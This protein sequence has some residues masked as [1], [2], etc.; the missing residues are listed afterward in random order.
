[1]SALKELEPSTSRENSGQ[2]Q[3]VFQCA[4]CHQKFSTRFDLFYHAEDC[5]MSAFE[6]EVHKHNSV[7]QPST[8]QNPNQNPGPGIIQRIKFTLP[9]GTIL[10]R[11]FEGT[12]GLV[13]KVGIIGK[14]K[15]DLPE[16]K[17]QN[18]EENDEFDEGPP[19]LECEAE[20]TFFRPEASQAFQEERKSQISNLLKEPTRK[21]MTCPICHL[22]LYRHNF[23]AHYR[24]HTNELPYACMYCDKR[25]RTSSTLKV[26]HRAHT[27]DKPYKCKN[28]DYSTVTK[29]NLDRHF[30][31]R[32][33]RG[34]LGPAVRV[35]RYRYKKDQET[36]DFGFELE[37]NLV[38]EKVDIQ[39]PIFEEVKYSDRDEAQSSNKVEKKRFTF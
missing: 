16:E 22:E 28:C 15:I 24:I 17:P 2:L 27:G 20:P 31:N 9:P 1:M 32:H 5:M 13:R 3:K 19:K 12:T 39:N 36:E 8:S 18:L 34:S 29:K 38:E 7:P 23:A 37:G 35:P 26:H 11:K 21:K 10:K 30:Q 14:A 33:V 4:E 6:R 25:F